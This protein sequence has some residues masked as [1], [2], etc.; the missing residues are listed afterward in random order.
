MKSQL[1][2]NSLKQSLNQLNN[3]YENNENT[4]D[5]NNNNNHD[6]NSNG[7]NVPSPSNHNHHQQQHQQQ[8][9][10]PRIITPQN[11]LS[12]SEKPIRRKST[13]ASLNKSYTQN[14]D[15]L[16]VHI[17]PSNQNIIAD[18]PAKQLAG[19]VPKDFFS[20]TRR[21]AGAVL[22][23]QSSSISINSPSTSLK[24]IFNDNP[25]EP[26]SNSLL[27]SYPLSPSTPS[28]TQKLTSTPT[29]TNSNNQHSSNHNHNHNNNNYNYNTMEFEDE[30]END[31]YKSV[32]HS[33]LATALEF[34]E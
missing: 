14:T 25:S 27:L 1:N 8:Q 23:S 12:S 17:Y 26:N 9:N 31:R 30:E 34:E 15:S 33:G 13:P 21:S 3:S 20:P 22:L 2:M 24:K 6:V 5:S 18:S 19:S 4:N 28:I 10:V 16:W 11:N 7:Y 32:E 29:T